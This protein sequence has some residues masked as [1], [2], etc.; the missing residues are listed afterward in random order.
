MRITQA[1][2]TILETLKVEKAVILHY[3]QMSIDLLESSDMSETRL[4]TILAK[5]LR[6]DGRSTGTAGGSGDDVQEKVPAEGSREENNVLNTGAT[7]TPIFDFSVPTVP[8]NYDDIFQAQSDLDL[9]YLLGLTNSN[10]GNFSLNGGNWS[11]NTSGNVASAFDLGFANNGIGG[12]S[13][14]PS[15]S[16]MGAIDSLD[17][18]FGFGGDSQANE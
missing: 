6:E 14:V 11:I 2:Q 9:S 4:G 17:S 18:V 13:T 1:P 16:W 12:G 8:T 10:E 7:P 5:T 15:Q 3:L